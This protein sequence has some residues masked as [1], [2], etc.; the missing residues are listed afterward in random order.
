MFIEVPPPEF[1]STEG[2]SE[3]FLPGAVT[4]YRGGFAAVPEFLRFFPVPPGEE[5]DITWS[6]GETVSTG[7]TG[8][9]RFIEGYEITGE[10][11]ETEVTVNTARFPEEHDPVSVEIL[12]LLGT[13]VAMVRFSPFCFGSPGSYLSSISFTLS[14]EEVPGGRQVTGT[15][16]EQLSPDAEVWW[17]IR[18]RSPESP[19]WGRP[20]ARIRVNFTGLYSIT[21]SELEQAGCQVTGVPSSS[22]A[23]FTGPAKMFDHGDPSDEHILSPA[24]IMVFDGDDGVFDGDDSLL[25]HGR[26]IWRWEYSADTLFRE[27]HRFDDANVYWLTWGG[28]QGERMQELPAPP[29][30]GAPVQQG[31]LALGFE[32]EILSNFNDPRT[33]WLWG[34]IYENS[35][36]YFYLGSPFSSDDAVLRIGLVKDGTYPW[37]HN[38]KVELDGTVVLDSLI[39][40]F[41]RQETHVIEGCE[42]SQGGNLLKVWSDYHGSAL[43]DYA[44]LLIPAQTVQSA[45]YPVR[46]SG[47]PQ[48]T[49]SLQVGPVSSEAM[50]FDLA[51]PFSPVLLVDWELS[52]GIADLSYD[53]QDDFAVIRAYEPD[54]IR[55]PLSIEPAG[56]GRLLGSMPE[57]DVLVAVPEEFLMEAE[58]LIGIYALRDR[59]I[60]MATYREIYDEFGQGVSDPGA[61]RSWV[62]WAIDC[63]SDPP[64]SLLL[65]GDGSNDPLGYNTGSRTLAPIYYE[66]PT[67]LCK[68]GFFTTVHE[69]MEFPELPVSRVPASS[70]SD[71]VLALQKSTGMELD[72]D[73][74]CWQNN[75]ILAA[76][77]EWGSSFTESIHT[78]TCEHLSEEVLP[79]SLNVI[80]HYL[81]EYPWPPG[82]TGEGLHPEKPEAASDLICLLNDGASSFTFFGHGSYDQMASEK[83]FASSMVGQLNNAPR[84][85][86]YNSFSC[87]N[88]EFNLSAGDCLA[89]NILFHPQG[90]AA[91][92]MACTGGSYSTPNGV[93]AEWLFQLMYGKDRLSVADALWLSMVSIQDD[94]NLLYC[95]L[96]DGGIRVPMATD[97]ICGITTPDTLYRGRT[98]TVG[99]QFSEETWFRFRCFE[100]ADTVTYT[101]PLPGNKSIDYLR[102]GASVYSGLN[103]TDAS[104]SASVSFFVPLQADTGSMGRTDGTGVEDLTL[105]TGY[106]WPVPL[107]DDGV[108]SPDSTGPVIRLSFP[109]AEEGEVPGVYQNTI[110]HAELSDPSGICVLGHDAGSIIICSVDGSYEDVTGL[111]SYYDGSSTAGSLEYTLPELLPGR[112]Q[113]RIVARDGMKNTGEATLEFDVF[114]GDPPMLEETGVYPN[115]G[116]GTRAFFFST[117]SAGNLEVTVYTVAGR[118]VWTSTISVS[119]GAGQVIWDGLDADGDRLAAGTYIYRMLFSGGS[120]KASAVDLMVVSP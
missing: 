104:G 55:A 49:I 30:G 27:P 77:D 33:G 112:H 4:R 16:F 91:V 1:R 10:G 108:H 103:A 56:P 65:I 72:P 23:L 61:V 20:W 37:E 98:N 78:L 3:I 75:V 120:G 26:D 69:G 11:F 28:T 88:G 45:G 15:L 94:R 6:A 116:R 81:I 29:S 97:G 113:A 109:E 57:G 80:K 17:R 42:I 110:L 14:H 50:I 34:Y 40:G 43:L 18:E 64:S 96:G 48:G 8:S 19:F 22:L 51:D 107:A 24:A 54:V 38:L 92:T 60:S 76:D 39:G 66:L 36:G 86:L 52:D 25:F 21:C 95:V 82:T 12:E 115:P 31:T 100:S 68:E 93:L 62:R 67:G 71:L 7:L 35:P 83:L 63:W 13:E 106:D 117:G 89:E 87:N 32:E 105:G 99:I 59:T 90:G 73:P 85:F 5:P 84:Y 53:P 79:R 44:E 119:G 41:M 46:L 114:Q 111:F 47:L 58:A 118:P 102:Y 9:E 2:Y 74:A 101:S 70:A